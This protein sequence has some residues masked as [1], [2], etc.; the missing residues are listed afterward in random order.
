MPAARNGIGMPFL[1]KVSYSLSAISLI[2][3]LS[4]RAV[5]CRR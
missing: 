1:R 5:G 4:R 3:E 2:P